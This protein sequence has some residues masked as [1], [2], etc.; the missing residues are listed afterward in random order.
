MA[1]MKNAQIDA[2]LENIAQQHLNIY[3]LEANNSDSD[4]FHD[5]AVW[6]IKSALEEAYRAG[7]AAAK[8]K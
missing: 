5:C 3:T 4:D 7:M 2:L 1:T 6:A 8:I